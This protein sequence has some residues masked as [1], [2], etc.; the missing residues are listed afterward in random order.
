MEIREYTHTNKHTPDGMK[1]T[2]REED[3]K[4]NGE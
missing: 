4:S 1:G 2:S 3:K